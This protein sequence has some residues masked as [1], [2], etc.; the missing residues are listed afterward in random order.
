LG[1]NDGGGGREKKWRRSPLDLLGLLPFFVSKC[2]RTRARGWG[3][4]EGRGRGKG[5]R[6][7]FLSWLVLQEE[8][9]EKGKEKKKGPIGQNSIEF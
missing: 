6:L 7:G 3:L 5:G 8:R 2:Y 4:R 9:G 1:V